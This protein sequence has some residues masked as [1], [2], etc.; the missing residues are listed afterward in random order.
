MSAGLRAA[1]AAVLAVW[2]T[3]WAT[4]WAQADP[5]GSVGAPSCAAPAALVAI[6]P[7]LGRGAARIERAETLTIV[8]FG[9]SSTK[10]FG[11]SSPAMSYPSRLER[12]LRNRF[13]GVDIR[14]VNR[15]VGG[16]DV[17]LELARLDRDVLAEQPDLVIWQVGTNAVLRRDD[18]SGDEQLIEAGVAAMKARGI[19]VV[20]MDLQYA[21][22]VL[23]RPALSEMER[24]IAAVARRAEVGYFRRFEI[25]RAWAAGDQL[26]PAAM[27]GPDGLH[28]TDASYGCLADRLASAIG[29]NLAAGAKIAKSRGLR[30][31]AVAV[32]P[33]P[34]APAA[35]GP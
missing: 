18:V 32:L 4:G 10:G 9:S 3:G 34:G 11:A 1:L 24:I 16:E 19:D 27:I 26:A 30:P 25:M 2:A 21:P 15:G 6:G 29:A 28:M 17:R 33:R 5:P 14:V 23:A 7:A 35:A 13:P 22:K 8:A 12:E 31:N 20:L